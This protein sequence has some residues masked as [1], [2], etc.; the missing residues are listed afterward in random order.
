[1]QRRTLLSNLLR[2]PRPHQP[3]LFRVRG[4]SGLYIAPDTKLGR[5]NTDGSGVELIDFQRP[6]ETGFGVNTFF[7]DGRRAI[8]VSHET[9]AAWQS[10]PFQQYKQSRSH[11]WI[12][13]MRSRQLTEIL[14]KERLAP[15]YT[16]GLLLPGE[17]R[18]TVSVLREKEQ[19]YVMNLDGTGQ[20]PI[21]QPTE[22]TYGTSLSPDGE[23]LA[24]HSNYQIYTARVDGSGRTKVAG[25]AKGLLY[26][27]TSWSPD[28]EWLVY[29]VCDTKAEPGHDWCDIWIGRPD[30]TENRALTQGGAALFDAAHGARGNGA[31]GS[32]LPKWAPDGAGI[33]YSRRRPGS[34]LPWE[35]NPK[36]ARDDHFNRV[37]K[38]ELAHGG[39]EL[40][41]VNPRNG[42]EQVLTQGPWDFRGE[43]SPDGRNILFCRAE[44]GGN[45]AIWLM[46]REGRHQRKLTQGV[47]GRGVDHPRWIPGTK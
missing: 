15:F 8:L 41:L 29:M 40:V 13:D 1:M 9:N 19:L 44:T 33:L 31:G 23:R 6:A 28:G 18:I 39:T 35:F 24:F 17:E 4:A 27:S 7:R 25:G 11:C 42:E 2:A 38:P 10:D 32:N 3:F 22:Y 20:V 34:K 37:F 45:A 14:T 36:P 46:D 43:W 47:D 5:M 16:A 26:F 12:W 30:G 21:T